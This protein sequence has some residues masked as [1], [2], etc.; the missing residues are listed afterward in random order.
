MKTAP[1]REICAIPYPAPMEEVL[2]LASLMAHVE[3]QTGGVAFHFVAG[4]MQVFAV[5][6]GR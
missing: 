1:V 5:E 2:D 6:G 3:E 4:S